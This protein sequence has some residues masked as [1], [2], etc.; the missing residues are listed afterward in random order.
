MDNVNKGLMIEHIKSHVEYPAKSDD[1]KEACA[2]MSDFSE[3]EKKW[4]VDHLPKGTYSSADEVLGA[5][6][7]KGAHA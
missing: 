5:I 4:F 1:I 7:W 3:E 2:E 6:G